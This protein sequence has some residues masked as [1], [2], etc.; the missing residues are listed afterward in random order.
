MV[1]IK[2]KCN[3]HKQLTGYSYHSIGKHNSSIQSQ[4]YRTAVGLQLSLGVSDSGY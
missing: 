3:K 1:E 4:K 2:G